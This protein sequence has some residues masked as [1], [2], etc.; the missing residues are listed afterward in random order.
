MWNW[1][2]FDDIVCI[3]CKDSIKRRKDCDIIFNKYKIPARYYL[4]DRHPNGSNHGCFE[5]HINIFKEAYKKGL[6]KIL[7]LEDDI[8]VSESLTK[9]NLNYCVNFL[10]NNNWDLFYFGAVPDMRNF[11][12]T[13]KTSYNKIYQLN[14]ICTHAY[15]INENVI[16]RYR[17][18]TYNNIPYDYLLRDD[19]RIKSFAFYPTLFYQHTKALGTFSQNTINNY[20]RL[21]EFYAY[22]VNIPYDILVFVVIIILFL[23]LIKNIELIK[24]M[25]DVL[26]G[27]FIMLILVTA[28]Y[29]EYKD[30]KR[31]EKRNRIK[32]IKDP[33]ERIKEYEFYGTFNYENNVNWRSIFIGSFISSLVIYLSL[34]NVLNCNFNTYYI[35]FIIIFLV[36]YFISDF[37]KFHLYRLMANKVRLRDILIL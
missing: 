5:S 33:K 3:S 28:I 8:V 16:K 23:L 24:K 35:L 36:Y 17:K 20:F 4:V 2:Y 13:K 26:I 15:A 25:S 12:T 22:Y 9:K 21:N 10:E 32:D 18:L 27:T 29:W 19:I 1:K 11:Y 34:K 14:G 6:K 37:K 31:L 7:I 30:Q